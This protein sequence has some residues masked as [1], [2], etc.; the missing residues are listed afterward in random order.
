MRAR[1]CRRE[2]K[3]V[4]S[5]KMWFLKKP[6]SSANGVSGVMI[7]YGFV[8]GERLNFVIQDAIVS[9]YG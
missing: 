9:V 7:V 3:Y 1:F 4:L 2:K 5:A 6:S 8:V